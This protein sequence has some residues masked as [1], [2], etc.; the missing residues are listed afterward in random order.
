[1]TKREHNGKIDHD[2]PKAGAG[3]LCGLEHHWPLRGAHEPRAVAKALWRVGDKWLAID[4][5]GPL[6][7]E[8]P[9][10]LAGQVRVEGGCDFLEYFAPI[11]ILIAPVPSFPAAR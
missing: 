2:Q 10:L 4:D 6:R 8:Q 9:R 5:G 1:M 3:S 7:R 11:R